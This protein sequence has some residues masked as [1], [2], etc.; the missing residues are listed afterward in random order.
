MK[1]L[2]ADVGGTNTRVALC[3]D[4]VI[5]QDSVR[6]FLNVGFESLDDVLAR[7]TRDL[8][9]PEI[10]AACVAI[11]GPVRDGIGRLTNLDW[12]MDAKALTSASGAQ[13]GHVINDLEAQGHALAHVESRRIFGPEPQDLTTRLVVGMGT[14]FNAAP[15]HRTASGGT[16]VVPSECGHITLPVWDSESL[17]LSEALRA[18]HGFAS[19]EEAFSGRGILAV[20]NHFAEQGGQ[21]SFAS[22]VDV[23]AAMTAAETPTV[24]RATSFF[25][26]MLG[27]ILGDLALIHL[28]WGGIYLIGGLARAVSPFLDDHGFG[29]GF[30]DKGRFADF[31]RD[32]GVFLVEDDFAALTGCAVYARD[33]NS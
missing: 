30:L 14:G 11:A 8:G 12:S 7:Y 23:I 1:I 10:D 33:A 28:P 25:C 17:A 3:D 4:A 9:N 22:S 2:S 31:N 24:R 5:R 26:G 19:V 27:R 20:F 18:R 21:G 16:Y 32:F 29:E 13:R 15:V 6:K